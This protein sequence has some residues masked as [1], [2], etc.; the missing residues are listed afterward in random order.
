MKQGIVI[1]LLA[2]SVTLSFG[3]CQKPV[4]DTP[5]LMPLPPQ[6][7]GTWQARD[8]DWMIVLDPNGT[9]ASA[10][11]PMG[12]VWI[13]PNKTT[14]AE[15]KD[16]SWSTYEGGDC[17]VKYDPVRRELYVLVEVAKVAIKYLENN[18]EGNSTDRFIGAVSEDGK[19]WTADWITQFDYGPRFPQDPNDVF[20]GTLI[21]DKVEDEEQ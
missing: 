3:G 2:A 21:F 16:G 11:I 8:S 15:M 13:R 12:Q 6:V 20:A 7:A 19:K 1:A 18:L 4:K 17:V 14:R 10:R 9:V 5:N